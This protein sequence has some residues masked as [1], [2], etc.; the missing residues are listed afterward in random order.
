MKEKGKEKKLSQ[1][2]IF[3]AQLANR[4]ANKFGDFITARGC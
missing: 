2:N 3:Q 1:I 4:K